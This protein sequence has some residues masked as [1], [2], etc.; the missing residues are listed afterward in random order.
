M[1][2]NVNIFLNDSLLK[3]G[4]DKDVIVDGIYKTLLTNSEDSID[5]DNT[6]IETIL[7][8]KQNLFIAQ[9]EAPLLADA[10]NL[11][12]KAPLFEDINFKQIKG[13]LMKFYINSDFSFMDLA[14]NVN[15][16][17]EKIDENADMIWGTFCDDSIS[18]DEIKVIVMAT[19]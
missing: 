11:A 3:S 1:N 16:L 4:D 15:K 17:S 8:D 9:G 2:N 6:D 5:I 12:F 13:L 18:K 7:Q 10:I 14:E 19:F